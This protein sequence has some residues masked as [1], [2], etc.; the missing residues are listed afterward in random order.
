MRQDLSDVTFLIP[1]RLDSVH[2]LEN[3]LLTVGFLRRYFSCRIVVWEADCYPNG[4]V[5][6]CLPEV[7]YR[8]IEDKDPVFYRT[9]YL[10]E[11]ARQ[12]ATPYLSLWDT[13]VVTSPVQIM[14][15][16]EALRKGEARMAY[17]YDGRFAE[18]SYPLR[19]LYR[20]TEEIEVLLQHTEKMKILCGI[21]GGA[22]FAEKD[23]YAEAGMEN[24]HF[25]GW[26]AED[27]ER[28]VRWKNLGYKIFRATG[29]L[30]HL[31][32]ARLQNSA[33]LSEAYRELAYGELLAARDYSGE[34]IRKLKDNGYYREYS[35]LKDV[36]DK[37]IIL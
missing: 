9:Y 12:V 34:E 2:R 31:T 6:R 23:A 29:M 4:L 11:M 35:R 17:P 15:A 30:F 14:Q 36:K 13:D 37:N 25:Y 32:H 19:E 8:F 28:L 18:V 5:E 26:G 24:E 1:L 20:K 33:Y 21:S 10:N 3:L 27:D 16:V 7:D 22:V